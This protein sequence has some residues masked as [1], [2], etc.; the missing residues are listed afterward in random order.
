MSKISAK[1]RWAFYQCPLCKDKAW[2]RSLRKQMG[3]KLGCESDAKSYA[4]W[5]L[6]PASKQHPMHI[7]KARARWPELSW[8]L[9]YSNVSISSLDKWSNLLKRRFVKIMSEHMRR[10]VSF[11]R[12]SSSGQA[13]QIPTHLICELLVTESCTWSLHMQSLMVFGR[14]DSCYTWVRHLGN[15]K[16]WYPKKDMIENIKY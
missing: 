12:T 9:F 3:I 2:A 5:L 11:A 14:V 15:A 13:W 10:G 1:V 7:S 4:Q 6:R 16:P 8:G